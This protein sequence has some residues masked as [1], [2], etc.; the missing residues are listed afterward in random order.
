MTAAQQ[1]EGEERERGKGGS[2]QC[3]VC[4]GEERERGKGGSNQ[5]PVCEGEER[6][7]GKGGSNQCPV[8]EG[9]ERERGKGG[10][11]QCPMCEEE[12]RERGKGGSNQCPMFSTCSICSRVLVQL[13][14]HNK[15]IQHNR[16][17]ITSAYQRLHM[18]SK[19]KS[20]IKE[21]KFSC[22]FSHQ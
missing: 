12:E 18:C 22:H 11:N 16:H 3:P 7:R 4:E 9:E 15:T 1:C 13:W 20:D 10:S 14:Q 19:N 6:E 8:C 21:D 17:Y 5:C 2:N